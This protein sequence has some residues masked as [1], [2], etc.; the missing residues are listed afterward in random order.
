MAFW[1]FPPSLFWL[2]EHRFLLLLWIY[3][4]SLPSS[5]S[6]CW[7]FVLLLWRILCVFL[8]ESSVISRGWLKALCS[9]SA[10]NESVGQ[11][12]SASPWEATELSTDWYSYTS[13]PQWLTSRLPVSFL[14]IFFIMCAVILELSFQYVLWMPENVSC[15]Q[16]YAFRRNFKSIKDDENI[17][18]A[19]Q[20]QSHV[21]SSS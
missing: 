10:D 1:F 14:L 7:C 6:L 16:S 3:K 21:S 12:T 15:Q 5:L 4:T 9:V 13:V 17:F 20:K 19:S 8:A 11:H 2:V 18:S